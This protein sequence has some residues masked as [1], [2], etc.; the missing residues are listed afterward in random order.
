[1]RLCLGAMLP[2]EGVA[3]ATPFFVFIGLVMPPCRRSRRLGSR[4][5]LK[6][7]VMALPR[8]HP[9]SKALLRPRLVSNQGMISYLIELKCRG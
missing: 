1:M 3:L 4:R 5:T 6:F 9:Y 8:R 2:S 7:L